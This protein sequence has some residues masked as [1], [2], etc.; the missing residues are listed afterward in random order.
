MLG[1]ILGLMDVFES[2]AQGDAIVLDDLR[3]GAAGA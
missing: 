2:V 1:D 3:A